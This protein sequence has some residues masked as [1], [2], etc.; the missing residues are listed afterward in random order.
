MPFLMTDFAQGAKAVTDANQAT[1]TNQHLQEINQTALNQ[2]KANLEKT[3]LSNLVTN[4]SLKLDDETR[5]SVSEVQKTPEW[6]DAVKNGDTAKQLDLIGQ[7][8]IKSGKVEEGTKTLA[9]AELAEGRKAAS[10]LKKAEASDKILANAVATLEPLTNEQFNSMKDRLSPE[11]KAAIKAQIPD[12]FERE[13]PETQKK[14]L[15]NLLHNT[16]SGLSTYKVET[17]KAIN[18]AHDDARIEAAQLRIAAT[19]AGAVAK[20]GNKEED[21]MYQDYH[22]KM[23]EHDKTN[24]DTYKK[25][26]SDI[27]EAGKQA[28]GWHF[29][30][31]YGGKSADQ[32]RYEGLVKQRDD[33]LR[34]DIEY[35]RNLIKG[36]PESHR[37]E[38]LTANLDYRESL[39]PPKDDEEKPSKP[40]TS[41]PTRKEGPTKPIGQGTKQAPLALPTTKEA[42]VKGKW[43]NT[44]KGIAR[45]TGTGFSLE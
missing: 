8:Q 25:L 44:S 22:K 14:Q 45:W 24:K 13:D 16:K 27:N 33:M 1:W 12:F 38:Q 10:D 39:L 32:E 26:T 37:K 29:A 20:A 21:R 3:T 30:N 15:Q 41:T 23:I 7:A 28:S 42:M 17:Q 36:L 31:M 6:Q 18:K 19:I 4:N 40:S 11:Q 34:A 9:Q 35:E 5:K 2:D 43:Y